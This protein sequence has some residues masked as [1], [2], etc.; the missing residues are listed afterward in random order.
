MDPP[1]VTEIHYPLVTAADLLRNVVLIIISLVFVAPFIWLVLASIDAHAGWG[2]HLPDLTLD[3]FRAVLTRL[4]FSA[5]EN[6]CYLALATSIIS[7]ALGYLAAYS[8]SRR[9][10]PLKRGFMLIIL[11]AT[12]L[13]VSLLLV[14]T[15]QMYVVF[16]WLDS[17]FT[18]SLF[19]AAGALPF[20]IW[21]LKSFIDAVP[22]E[23]E[24]AAVVEGAGIFQTMLRVT[25]PLTLPGLSVTAIYTFIAAWGAFIAPLILDGDPDHEPAPIAIFHFMGNH[26]EF[27]FGQ[28]AAYSLLFSLPVVLLYFALS[29]QFSGAFTF[30]GGLKG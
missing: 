28:L 19:L 20:A 9:Y 10:V 1:A 23:L 6:S 4:G 11:F 30:G 25:V 2:I 27:Q 22:L 12:G 21:M 7:T 5:L 17:R 18:T 13:P 14:P 26:G 24:E 29:R 3:N 16:G 8:L 15:Y